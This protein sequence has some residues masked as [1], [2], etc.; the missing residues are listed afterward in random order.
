MSAMFNVRL[1]AF[2][3]VNKHPLK[4]REPPVR[5]DAARSSRQ[6][7]RRGGGAGSMPESLQIEMP[8][9]ASL[10]DAVPSK[11]RQWRKKYATINIAVQLENE[12]IDGGL[13]TWMTCKD[14][15]EIQLLIRR[16][17]M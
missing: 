6:E 17:S 12:L 14:E 15:S 9:P 4:V 10:L 5:V 8:D 3:N 7:R 11:I 1:G 13:I 16:F 2:K